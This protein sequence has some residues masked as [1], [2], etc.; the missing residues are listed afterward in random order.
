[1]YKYI[2]KGLL[3]LH[4]HVRRL[5]LKITEYNFIDEIK[6]KNEDALEFVVENY[7]YI[8]VN[9]IN[10]H[11]FY[12]EDRKDE[13]L[14]DCL[15]AIWENIDSYDPEIAKFSS[16]IGGIAKFKSMD[17]IKKYLKDNNIENIDDQII[18][19]EDENIDTILTKEFNEQIQEL[20]SYLSKEDRKIF[21]D[22][23]FKEK[24]AK[25]ISSDLNIKESAIYNRLSRGR[26]KL[27][28]I[29][30]GIKDEKK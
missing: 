26:N 30:G 29:W 22:T 20:L 2:V 24:S 9:I 4:V 25:D 23:Y 17:Y 5:T 18:L 11:L 21:I 27:K 8:L 16:W 12:L 28:L 19:T 15:F 7:S 10:K 13:C 14:N 6:N 1:M 3:V